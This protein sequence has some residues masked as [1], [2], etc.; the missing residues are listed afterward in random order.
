MRRDETLKR[1]EALTPR[2]DSA[3]HLERLAG[4]LAD[5]PAAW[6]AATQEQRNKLARCLF[7]EVW[8]KDKVVVGVKPRPELEPFFRLNYEEFP[9]EYIEGRTSRRDELSLQHCLAVLLIVGFAASRDP[10]LG[11]ITVQTVGVPYVPGRRRRPRSPGPHPPYYG[12]RPGTAFKM[13]TL[14]TATH[15]G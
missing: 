8:V 6:E 13:A 4:F 5:V 7:D 10:V 9:K 15:W 3:E 1:L 11:N 12:A 2:S 14:C